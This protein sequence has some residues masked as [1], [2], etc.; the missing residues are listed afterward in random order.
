[1]SETADGGKYNQA[2][3][4]LQRRIAAG[5]YPEG[6]LPPATNLAAEFGV[7]VKTIQRALQQ[8]DDAGLTTGRQG[9]R[10]LIK[11]DAEDTSATRYEQ[12]AADVLKAIRSGM[13]PAGGRVPSETELAIEHRA[14][15]ATIRS[16]LEILES[17]G[18]VVKRAGRRYAVGRIAQ[19]DLAYERV[20]VQIEEAI[21]DDRFPGGRLPGENK[22]AAEYGVSRPT[23][24]QA[25]MRL[26]SSRLVYAAPKQ[27]WFV[28]SE[29]G[30]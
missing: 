17:S 9:R 25:L 20:A 28:A 2:A 16:A 22:L 11:A 8:L 19:S 6:V 3:A 15:R 21:R 18:Q 10:R 4:E 1:V 7:A 26:Q 30:S 23:I 12:V 24:R 5:S 13:I 14:S 29:G 27:G